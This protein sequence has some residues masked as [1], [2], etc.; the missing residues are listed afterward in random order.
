[1]RKHAETIRGMGIAVTVLSAAGLALCL[2]CLLLMALTGAFFDSSL[3]DM[4][5]SELARSGAFDDLYGYGY[6]YGGYGASGAELSGILALLLV[7]GGVLLGWEGI[8]CILTLVAGI[9]AMKHAAKGEKLDK[10]FVW[11]IV[12]A[13]AALLGGRLVTMA[14]LIATAALSNSDRNAMQTAQW[15]AQSFASSNASGTVSSVHP[16]AASSGDAPNAAAPNGANVA[17]T[18]AS[19]VANAEKAK[20]YPQPSQAYQRAY[21][22]PMQAAPEADREDASSGE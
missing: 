8:T 18:A 5:A 17:S 14:L 2:L 7:I 9:M 11:S 12:G 16:G 13:V 20:S 10:I 19:T 3:L 4:T 15:Q 21:G 6:G 1:M 22:S